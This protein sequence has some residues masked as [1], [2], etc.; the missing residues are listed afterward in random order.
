MIQVLNEEAFAQRTPW[1]RSGRYGTDGGRCWTGDGRDVTSQ[2]RDAHYRTVARSAR[3][4]VR[5]G[6]P[7][8]NPRHYC[9]DYPEGA[10][11]A[12]LNSF[13]SGQAAAAGVKCASR[14]FDLA[15][16][17]PFL[18]GQA[19]AAAHLLPYYH[20][21]SG[22]KQDKKFADRFIAEKGRQSANFFSPTVSA[23]IPIGAVCTLSGIGTRSGINLTV[24]T[25]T[26][27][28][29]HLP[30]SRAPDPGVRFPADIFSG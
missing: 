14:P 16:S 22:F 1:I 12:L 26:D 24:N 21:V 19:A 10:V 18:S 20:R 29:Q 9:N 27:P 15:V 11:P 7:T 30:D 23:E 17:V 25:G 4:C 6:S 3:R 28:G 13:L 2:F 8:G 5:G